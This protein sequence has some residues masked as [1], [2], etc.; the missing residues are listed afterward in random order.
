M[1]LGRSW[2]IALQAGVALVVVWIFVFTWVWLGTWSMKPDQYPDATSWWA[3]YALP[4]AAQA[5]VPAIPLA[6]AMGLLV[7]RILRGRL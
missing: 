4:R 6:A 2:R 3:D 7:G 5:L 1:L